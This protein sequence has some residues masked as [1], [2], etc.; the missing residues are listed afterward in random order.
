[1]KKVGCFIRNEYVPDNVTSIE[2]VR[3]DSLISCAQS[4]FKNDTCGDGWSYQLSTHMCHFYAL[5][6]LDIVK[7]QPNTHILDNE[8]TIG[9]ATGLKSCS[10]AGK[11][12]SNILLM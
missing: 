6:T 5:G 9:W 12:Y 2:G 7:L 3:Q 8:L 1:M 4:C 10:E 11:K